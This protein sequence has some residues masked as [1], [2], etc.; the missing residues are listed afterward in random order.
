VGSVGKAVRGEIHIL[1]PNEEELPP[2]E[3]G[4]IFFSGGGQF[5]YHKDPEKT[6]RA[7]NSKGWATF[8]DIG[9]LDEEGYLYLTDR[10]DYVIISG[11]VNIYPQEAEN[12]LSQHPEVEDVAVFG[13]PNEEYG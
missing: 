3:S 9:Y 4:L 7:H 1:G 11:G 6:R 5:V 8:G 2:G 10:R 13:I 12:V